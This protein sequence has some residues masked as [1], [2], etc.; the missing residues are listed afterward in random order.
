MNNACWGLCIEG[1]T[2]IILEK[3]VSNLQIG[4]AT[5]GQKLVP[6]SLAVKYFKEFEKENPNAVQRHEINLTGDNLDVSDNK[7]RSRI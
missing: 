1:D 2:L 4:N 3:T 7:T 5:I 6:S